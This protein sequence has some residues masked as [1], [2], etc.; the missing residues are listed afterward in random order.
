MNGDRPMLLKRVTAVLHTRQYVV[1]FAIAL[2]ALDV[3]V[4]LLS[5]WLYREA[6]FAEL[7]TN[8]WGPLADAVAAKSAV[9]AG[10]FVVYLLLKTWLRAGYVRSLTGPFHLGPANRGQFARLLGLE[11]IL[12][13][14]AAGAVGAGLLAGENVTVAGVMVIALLALYLAIIY[15]DYIVILAGV[16][17]IRAIVLSVRTVRVA[18]LPS[19]LVLL[20][21]TMVGD[22]TS[23][24]LSGSVTTSLGRA[25]PMLLV[26]FLAMGVV[27]F[28]ADVVLV[29]IYLSA[30]EAGRVT[31]EAGKPSR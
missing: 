17:P 12:E 10:V 6:A 15:A 28:V 31:S 18:L 29:V 26:Q 9:I 8:K 21:V 4:P 11:L 22:A 7:L 24:L 23:R 5:A 1:F 3:G 13:L 19:A 2:F 16:G 14:I 20:T 30:V 27:V 25:A